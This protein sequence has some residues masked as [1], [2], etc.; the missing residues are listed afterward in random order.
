MQKNGFLLRK[1]RNHD[2]LEDVYRLTY[3]CYLQK[4][5]CEKN[6]SNMLVHYP[7]FDELEETTVF[8]VEDDGGHLVGTV[9]TTKDNQY[10]LHV[11]V[12][13]HSESDFVRNENTV[14]AS[15]WRIAVDQ[16]FRAQPQVAR[17]LVDG[18]VAY[19]HV[20]NIQT[21]LMTLHP[22]HERF[23]E[24]YLNCKT[25]SRTDALKDIYSVAVLMRWDASRCPLK[26][27]LIDIIESNT[28]H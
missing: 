17:L 19:W 20:S 16:D 14:L 2:E 8:V 9:S 28:T 23:Y 1:I 25:L 7:Q 13:F 3:K 5:Y 24:R 6:E 26:S 27:R 10:G 4:G 15:S 12:D 21:C 22:D 18:S 11:D